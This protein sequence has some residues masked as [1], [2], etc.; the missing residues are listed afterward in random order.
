MITIAIQSITTPLDNL[1][2]LLGPKM[3]GILY[4]VG[5]KVGVAAESVVSDYPEP[6][7][8]PLAEYYTRTSKDG[9][10]RFKSKF[11]SAAQQGYVFHL[12]RAGK[13]PFRRSGQ[14]ARSITSKVVEATASSVSVAVGTNLSYA[15]YVIGTPSEGQ[16][17]YHQGTW[18]PLQTDLDTHTSVIADAAQD[19]LNKQIDIALGG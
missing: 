1:D 3:P 12:L 6:S 2:A 16:S 13:I 19:E 14:L 4:A 8:K 17:H 15:K 9:K 18:S 11:K 7:G 5:A 10:R